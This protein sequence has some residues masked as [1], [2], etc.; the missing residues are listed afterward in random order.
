MTLSPR[1]LPVWLPA[2]IA[3]VLMALTVASASAQSD[4]AATAP[5]DAL[6]RLIKEYEAQRSLIERPFLTAYAQRLTAL[7]ESLE[8]RRDPGTPA[9]AAEIAA[10]QA[11]LNR[12]EAASAATPSPPSPEPTPTTPLE[13]APKN[14]RTSGGASTAGD[15][16]SPIHFAGKDSA[17][18]WSLP[19]LPTGR[20]RLLWRIACEVGAGAT[21]RLTVDGQAPRTLEIVP[22]SA[23]GDA[24]VANLGEFT[25][26]TAPAWVQVEV[27]S[28]PGRLPKLGPSFSL[29][30]MILIP[31]GV[32]MPGL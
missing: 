20:Y 18:E 28:L 10:V 8:K 17:A 24:V 9:V 26:L 19:K 32:T 3:P 23:S 25:A 31:P 16:S 27:L 12:S 29:G 6:A 13:L 14:A 2:L 7:H 22:T 4:P 21:V 11:K 5:E 30:K 1:P 15:D